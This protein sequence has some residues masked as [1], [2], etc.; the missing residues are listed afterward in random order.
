MSAGARRATAS[1]WRRW[2]ARLARLERERAEEQVAALT[3]VRAVLTQAML[4]VDTSASGD[5]VEALRLAAA[6]LPGDDPV[7]RRQA[8]EYLWHVLGGE[9]D[10]PVRW[11]VVSGVHDIHLGDLARW[12]R[13]PGDGET[14]L[15]AATERV[16]AD[17]ASLGKE[18]S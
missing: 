8:L 10:R 16:E 3:Q 1:L 2:R 14:V 4:T 12:T 18:P 5:P 11:N 6:R 7:P 15:R 13:G 9:P 17:I